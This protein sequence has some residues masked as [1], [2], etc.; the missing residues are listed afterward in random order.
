M[1]CLLG[2]GRKLKL[3]CVTFLNSF[4]NR[5]ICDLDSLNST[6]SHVAVFLRV[7][8]WLKQHRFLN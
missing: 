2:G 8:P 3:R 6:V 7:A 5:K 4:F 1:Q